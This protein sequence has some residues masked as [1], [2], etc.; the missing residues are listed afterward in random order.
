VKSAKSEVGDMNWRSAS[1]K[2]SGKR[3]SERDVRCE[4]RVERRRMRRGECSR[5]GGMEGSVLW[6]WRESRNRR[7]EGE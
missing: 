4:M 6:E 3:R 5:E 1:A 7:E 2:A